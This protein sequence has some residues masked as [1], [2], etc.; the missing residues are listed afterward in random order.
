MTNTGEEYPLCV[1]PWIASSTSTSAHTTTTISPLKCAQNSVHLNN[2]IP[3]YSPQSSVAQLNASSSQS[4]HRRTRHRVDAGEPRGC[5]NNFYNNSPNSNSSSPRINNNTGVNNFFIGHRFGLNAG[6]FNE[7]PYLSQPM[8]MLSEF[9]SG[10]QNNN[11]SGSGQ[12][13]S[14]TP[15]ATVT[16][17]SEQHKSK[18]QQVLLRE[19]L[20]KAQQENSAS[21]G[22]QHKS[23]YEDGI[24]ETN[25]NN[26]EEKTGET[27]TN[28][29]SSGNKINGCKKRKLYQPQKSEFDCTEQMKEPGKRPFFILF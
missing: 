21:L 12:R 24:R 13:F 10:Q 16:S 18:Q 3:G 6:G 1:S 5:F 20:Q 23:G 25:N 7:P 17:T 22:G 11:N 9:I 15:S 28:N 26:E 29:S 4:S 2:L 27:V 8:K 14:N 19:M